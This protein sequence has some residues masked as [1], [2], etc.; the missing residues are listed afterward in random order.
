MDRWDRIIFSTQPIDRDRAA[1][2]VEN[3]DKLIELPMPKLF[4]LPSPPNDFSLFENPGIDEFSSLKR[5]LHKKLLSEIEKRT[6]KASWW[7]LYNLDKVYFLLDRLDHR[8]E[9]LCNKIYL[10]CSISFNNCTFLERL[11]YESS[12]TDPWV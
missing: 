5:S 4:F 8:F 12:L 9:Q 3:A 6:G 2:V 10:E 1:V 7:E 11:D